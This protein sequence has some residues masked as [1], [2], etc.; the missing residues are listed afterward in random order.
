MVWFEVYTLQQ[1]CT[2]LV[3]N[4][5]FK[6]CFECVLRHCED[7]I[8]VYFSSGLETRHGAFF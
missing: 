6:K 2:G 4:S 1:I 7:E 3:N 8:F 5:S